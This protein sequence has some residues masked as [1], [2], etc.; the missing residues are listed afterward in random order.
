MTSASRDPSESKA[1]VLS[2]SPADE[3]R[4]PFVAPTV[5]A[6]LGR[7]EIRSVIGHGAMATVFRARD[8]QLGR[9]VAIKVMTMAHA[10][11]GGASER[12]R[13]EAHAVAT[14]KH[15]GIVEIYDFVDATETEPSYIVAELISGPTLRKVL[16][17]CGGRVLPEIA[18]LVAVP[19]CEALAAAHAR[20]IVHRDV[21]PDNVMIESN[22]DASRVVLT[23]FGIAHI[24]GME[25]MTATGALVGSPAY[26]SPEQSRGHDVGPRSDIWSVGA[27]LYEMVTGVV[28]F[29]GK[30][31]YTVIASILRGS[32]RRP[33]QLVATV[34]PDFESMVLRCLKS[35]SA[36]RYT[37]LSELAS[38]L[39]EFALAAGLA[40]PEKALRRYLDDPEKTES[41]LR[42]KVADRAVA[43]ARQLARRGQLARA[44]AE[45]G[46]AT[47]YMPD[48]AGAERLL[49]RLSASRLLLRIV[50]V[51]AGFGAA[52]LIAWLAKPFLS[53][54]PPPQAPPVATVSLPSAQ[55][56]SPRPAAVSVSAPPETRKAPPAPEALPHSPPAAAFARPA[57][58]A[59]PAK[60]STH[61][62]RTLRTTRPART[63]TAEPQPSPPDT[64]VAIVQPAPVQAAH[65]SPAPKAEPPPLRS[66]TI[67]LFA[68]GGFCYPSLDDQPVRDLMPVFRDVPPGKHKIYCSRTKQSPKE[69][70]GE[71]DLRPGARI[72]RTVAEENGRLTVARPR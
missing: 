22:G 52:F 1:A 47:A 53:H 51:L 44:L 34:G 19:L 68:R 9:D 6:T 20:G 69:Y 3:P 36:E 15:P 2:T 21:K 31:P 32:F 13:R 17:A 35:N 63:P 49:R 38:E 50:V 61:K 60:A 5:G 16:E 41:E 18:A 58:A 10:A 29:A 72:E 55:V 54:G 57:P 26:M 33:S 40:P 14:L 11:R 25:T 37:C 62:P 8:T 71:V 28:P 27:M 56:A 59:H 24:T 64:T 43:R 42:P 12:F 65:P 48:H 30:D 70:A 46:H 4:T 39:R 66:G 7:Y 67:A 45:I 23:D